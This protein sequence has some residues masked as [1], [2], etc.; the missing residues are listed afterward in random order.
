MTAAANR[1]STY[2][3]T[4]AGDDRGEQKNLWTSMLGS[5]ASGKR[6]PEKN[7]LVLGSSPAAHLPHANWTR[8]FRFWGPR[9]DLTWFRR[10]ARVPEGVSRFAFLGRSAADDR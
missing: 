6:L 8:A 9:A 5:V 4:S 10:F 3:S 1:V 7:V 2:T